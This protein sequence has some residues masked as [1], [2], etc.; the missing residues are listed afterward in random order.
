MPIV[1]KKEDVKMESVFVKTTG[2]VHLAALVRT[3]LF[4]PFKNKIKLIN[5]EQR[6]E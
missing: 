2:L 1:M 4:L 6:F 5:N 3:I